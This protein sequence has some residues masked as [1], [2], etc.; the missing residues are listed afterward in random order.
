M[1]EDD[2]GTVARLAD[3]AHAMCDVLD[4]LDAARSRSSWQHF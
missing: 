3:V 4:E 2:A 1:G